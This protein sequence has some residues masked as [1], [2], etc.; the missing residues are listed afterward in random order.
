LIRPPL[1]LPA[2]HTVGNGGCRSGDDGCAG[3]AAK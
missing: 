1:R 3:H 2:G